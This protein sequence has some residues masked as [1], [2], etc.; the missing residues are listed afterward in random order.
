MAIL[1][2][3]HIFD[4]CTMS[5]ESTGDYKCPKDLLTIKTRTY[6]TFIT[7]RTRQISGRVFS[8]CICAVAKYFSDL[9]EPKEAS[10]GFSQ[11]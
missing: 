4:G 5:I 7:N 10:Q 3:T 6:T 1:F 2:F 9:T 11:I 8:N